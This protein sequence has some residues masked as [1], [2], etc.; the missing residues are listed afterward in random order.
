MLSDVTDFFSGTKMEK[1]PVLLNNSPLYLF[2]QEQNDND[3]AI[4]LSLGPC[5]CFITSDSLFL[6]SIFPYVLIA[7]FKFLT[8]VH[9]FDNTFTEVL[10][11]LR[12]YLSIISEL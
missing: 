2:S 9:V 7:G 11:F 8:T 10:N 12:D 1:I 6:L 4:M 3:I 5:F